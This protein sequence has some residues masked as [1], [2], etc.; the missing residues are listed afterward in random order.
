V[1]G[2]FG[3]FLLNPVNHFPRV[4]L[5]AM[6]V[7][8]YYAARELAAAWRERRGEIV[9]PWAII[10]LLLLAA[11]LLWP[12]WHLD[13]RPWLVLLETAGALGLFFGFRYSWPRP[14][15]D[16]VNRPL[17]WLA[18]GATLFGFV[19]AYRDLDRVERDF[20]A[21]LEAVRFS[22]ATTG[23]LGGGD[24][25]HF[26]IPRGNNVSWLMDLPLDRLTQMLNDGLP[27]VMRALRLSVAIEDVSDS[28]GLLDMLR[29][30]AAAVGADPKR[31]ASPYNAVAV[32]PRG[33]RLFD[34][35]RYAA[36]R[37][38]DMPPAPAEFWPEWSRAYAELDRTGLG[39]QHP[40]AARL[41]VVQRPSDLEPES[42]EN[43][44]PIKIEFTDRPGGVDEYE[45]RLVAKSA[46]GEVLWQHLERGPMRKAR[47][48]F[49]VRLLPILLDRPETAT[50]GAIAVPNDVRGTA[51]FE[52]R[53]VPLD[54]SAPLWVQ[55]RV[56]D[57]W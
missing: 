48:A 17:A 28:E 2:V 41:A 45:I 35:G 33:Q 11:R 24:A 20:M 23:I 32:D 5:P 49:G 44:R 15:L 12:Q 47:G 22:G 1:G 55:I 21:R 3:V 42:P 31:L 36:Y 38:E 29:P 39:A 57:W 9:G 30:V 43:P 52:V 6:P 50:D 25:L 40:T 54:G 56:P 53:A 7:L 4:L 13:A 51:L 8:C 46:R 14:W 18:V 16:R 34:N 26:L 10:A 27:V 37:L 19:T